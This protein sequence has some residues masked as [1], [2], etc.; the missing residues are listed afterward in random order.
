MSMLQP[1]H[2]LARAYFAAVTA[3]ELPDRLLTD[4]FS[5][6]TTG[7]GPMSKSAYQD[8]IRLLARLCKTPIQFTIDAI[9]A[10]EDRVL[11]EARSRTTLTNGEPYANTYVFSFRIR[12]GRIAWIGEHMNLAIVH[13]KLVPLMAELDGKGA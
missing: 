7:T 4:D 2:D 1:Y 12:E 5:A 8:A 11:A 13:E 9:T 6:W 3:G 10:E